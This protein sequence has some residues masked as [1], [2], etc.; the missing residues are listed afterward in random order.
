MIPNRSGGGRRPCRARRSLNPKTGRIPI[1]GI[2]AINTL[3][4]YRSPRS[5]EERG[6]AKMKPGRRS[7]PGAERRQTRTPCSDRRSASRPSLQSERVGGSQARQPAPFPIENSESRMFC[8]LGQGEKA[9]W[10]TRIYPG[11]RIHFAKFID[12]VYI[13]WFHCTVGCRRKGSRGTSKPIH[14][15]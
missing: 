15:V 10:S 6:R 9:L 7:I 1:L 11:R 13:P 12:I 5:A 2:V 8:L 4:G 14:V 3:S